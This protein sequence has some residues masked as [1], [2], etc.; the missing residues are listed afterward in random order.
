MERQTPPVSSSAAETPATAERL[1]RVSP[2]D[3][4]QPRFKTVMRGFGTQTASPLRSLTLAEADGLLQAG[5][6]PAGS[7]E[8]KIRAGLDF[9]R[10]G[11]QEVLIT[12][13]EH[14]SA[15]LAGTTGTHIG[16]A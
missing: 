2:L 13:P 4:R 11:G 1:M 3:L 12:D 14:L 8:P 7:M 16:A 9:L 10:A 5:E 6:F 15:A